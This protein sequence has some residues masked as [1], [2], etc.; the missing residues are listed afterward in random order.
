[1]HWFKIST[2]RARLL[3]CFVL[4]TILPALG[5]SAGSVAVGY[6]NGRQQAIDR[7]ESVAALKES[8]IRGWIHALQEELVIASN[9]DCAFER[10]SVVLNLAQDNKYYDFYNKAVRRRLQGFVGQSPQLQELF[11]LD[12]CGRVALSTDVAQE[13][14]DHSDQPYFQMGLAGPYAQLPFYADDTDQPAA[15]TVLSQAQASVIVV[16]PVIG[17]HGRPMGVIAA[18]ASVEDLHDI[19]GERTGLGRTGKTYLVDSNRAVLSGL[20]LPPM[21]AGRSDESPRTMHVGGIDAVIDGQVNSSGV[22]EDYRGVTAVGV[23]RWLP[24]LQVVLAAEQDLS[25]GFRAF[26]EI[27]GVNLG[28]ALVAVLLAVGASLFVT[29]SISDPLIN[30]VG[31]ATQIAAG[32]LDRVAQVER[33]DEVGALAQAFNSMTAQLRT[34]INS[35]EQRVEERTCALREANLALRRRALQ[36]E[37]SARVSREVTSIL[38]IDDLLTQVVGLI[39]DAFDYYH[40]HIFMVDQAAK[41]LVLRAS[42]VATGPQHQRLPV[43][44]GSVNGRVVHSHE[45]LVV[46]DVTQDPHYLADKRLP[47]TRSELVIPLR[48]GDQVI[49]TLDVQS[50]EVNAFTEEDVL[51]IQSLGD[52]IAI[53][54]DNARL[55]D[56][57]RELAVLE[58]RTRLARE[59]HDSVTQ[60]L[61]SLVLLAEGWRRAAQAGGRAPVEDYLSRIGEITQQALKEMRLLIHELRP[62]ALEREG[63]LGALHRRL[64]AV[65]K[66]VGVNARILADDLIQLPA[67]VEEG[68]YRIAQEAL[69]NALK[70]AGADKVVV[71]IWTNDGQVT[72]EVTDD[73]CG[74]DPAG[75]NHV[76][77]MGLVGMQERAKQLGGSLTVTSAPGGGTTVR[78]SIPA[79]EADSPIV[80][81]HA[82][83]LKED[84]R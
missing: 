47:D 33:D 55:Y 69:N 37:T 83:T 54:I 5:I 17:Q 42:S 51:V 8:T 72:L 25:E 38:D 4:M 44:V 21:N 74:F 45:A 22:Y 59:L 32:D 20:R 10:I 40:V 6:Y 77:G 26:Y 56:R 65:E 13:G 52:Q 9:T 34:L 71:R 43:G 12:L 3:V 61:Y 16:I 41:Q 46:N 39:R 60:S 28:I 24:D 36:L 31:T 53:A 14:K 81:P 66:R 78:A 58:E 35:L 73:G 76:G 19:L 80:P 18:R 62:P 29:R 67:H 68:L 2:I 30:L 50:A 70:H 23:Y 27:L 7:L 15:G 64:D 63:L 84:I 82:P 11:L 79:R 49:G 75:A 48:L 1:M 57:S